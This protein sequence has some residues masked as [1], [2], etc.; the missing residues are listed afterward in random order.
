MLLFRA[1]HLA[2]A[3]LVL[4]LSPCGLALAAPALR[5]TLAMPQPQTHYFEVE[6]ALTDFGKPYTDVKMPV[7]APGSYLVREFAK[8]VEGFEAAAG[9]SPLRTEKV[10]KNTWRVYH[11]KA[12]N[13]TVRYKVYA[14]ELSVRTSFVDA[15]HGYVNGTSVFMYPDGGQQLPSTLEVKP[16]PGWAQVST[17]L[18]PAG[19]TFTFRS[20]NYDELAD[21]PI[22]IGNQQVLTFTANGTPHTVAMFGNPKFDEARLLQSM[23]RVCEEAHRVVGRNP[24]DR[25]VFIVHNIERGTGGLEHLFSTTL[26]VSRTA[27]STEAGW[28]GFLGLVA[29]EYFHL[30]NVK[31]IRPVALGPFDYDQENYT[32][33][34]WVSEGGTEYFAN[35]IVQRAGLLT[36]DEYLGDLSNVLS[37]V[38]NTP[39][40]KVQSAAESSFDAWI[41]YYR[42][43]ENSPNTGI[44]YYDKGELIGAVLDLLVIQETKGQKHLDDVMRLLYDQY[45]AKLGRGFTDAEYQDAVAKVAGRRFD[46]FF[47]RHV[48]GTET[49]PYETALGY[50]G[51][52]LTATPA[53]EPALGASISGAG[54]RQTVTSVLRNGSAWQG[55]LNVGDEILSVDGLRVTDDVN[56]LL[57]GRPVGSQVKLL[58]SRDGQIKEL[59]F[60]LL[61]S[62]AQRYRIERQ[63]NPTAEQ[64]A[65][66]NKWLPVRK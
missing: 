20:S 29:H 16:A 57:T 44:S 4:L 49:L 12:K 27:Y 24:L 6:M 50:A 51:L 35:L 9:S 66:L 25:Y 64:Q 46:D 54:G 52:K 10:A 40:N 11:P 55:G 23:Q 26:S 19:G 33:M 47:R 13:F 34:L 61:A 2:A 56:R 32:R 38:E 37:R 58:V 7:W 42:P 21:S 22:E 5:Y 17:S 60:P 62:T 28:K 48:Y 18:K 53:T 63:A 8:N 15:A 41:K 30:W 36:P 3:V 31:R 1:R 45:Y 65:V 14:F 39:G 59:N 43:N